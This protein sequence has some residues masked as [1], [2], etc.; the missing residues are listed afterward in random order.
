MRQPAVVGQQPAQARGEPDEVGNVRVDV[1][2]D[3]QVGRPVLGAHVRAGL[4]REERGESG[5]PRSRAA[6]AT[7][8]AGSTPSTGCPRATTCCSR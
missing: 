5:I 7:F 1:V 3:H 6:S 4:R 8:A 2:G